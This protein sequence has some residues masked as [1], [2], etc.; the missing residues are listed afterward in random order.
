MENKNA[1]KTLIARVEKLEKAVFGS[2]KHQSPESFRKSKGFKGATG[3]LRLLISKG[4]FNRKHTFGEI[5][6]ALGDYGYHY[7]NQA[8]QTPL[9]TLSKPGGPLVGFKEQGK[10][11]YAKRK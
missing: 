8:V 5:K 2:G 1:L 7:S 6:K 11:V 10:K 4:F 9:N 3:G